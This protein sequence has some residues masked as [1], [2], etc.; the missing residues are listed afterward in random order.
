MRKIIAIDAPGGSGKTTLAEKLAARLPNAMLIGMDYFAYPPMRN[1][2]GRWWP[3]DVKGYGVDWERVRDQVMIPFK[4]GDGDMKYQSLNWDNWG[5]DW[6]EIPEETNFLIVEG[7]YSHRAELRQYADYAI[8]MDADLAEEAVLERIRAR[9]GEESVSYW[10]NEFIPISKRYMSEHKTRDVV[11][12]IMD[13][14]SYTSDDL[15]RI[16]KQVTHKGR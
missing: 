15:D 13:F 1:G 12:E 14:R 16:V 7:L 5:L 9:D 8:W 2:N 10:I 4:N 6:I 3:E 11:D